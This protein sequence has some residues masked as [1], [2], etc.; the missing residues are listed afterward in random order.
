ME[1]EG[2]ASPVKL[3]GVPDPA[4]DV[5]EGL[6]VQFDRAGIKQQERIASLDARGR[7]VELYIK[8]RWRS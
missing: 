8:T 6:I 2:T 5:E 7:G 4:K 3:P 1:H